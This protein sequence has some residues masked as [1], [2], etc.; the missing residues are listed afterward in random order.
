[1]FKNKYMKI[2]EKLEEENAVY[3]EHLSQAVIEIEKLKGFN[4]IVNATLNFV[5]SGK[6]F[7]KKFLVDRK[8]VSISLSGQNE[9]IVNTKKGPVFILAID[10]VEN[11]WLDFNEIEKK[12]KAK[13]KDTK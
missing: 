12:P 10:N 1:M 13:K 5:I 7:T 8:E 11:Y 4:D 2:I 6:I 9:L 3:D